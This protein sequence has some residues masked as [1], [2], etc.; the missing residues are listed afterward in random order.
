MTGSGG[1]PLEGIRVVELG[2]VIAGPAAAAVLGDWGASVVKIE[3]PEG[4]P[5]RGNR[6]TSYFQ[7]DNRGKRS[8]CLNLKTEAG[9]A[10]A[11]ALLGSADVFVT[12][13]RSAA[14]AR[15]GLDYQTLASRYPRLVYAAITGYGQ[16][17]PAAGKA[18]Y[19]IG[20]YWSRS[21]MALALAPEGAEPPV[22]RP[23]QGDHP[24][25]LA[26]AAGIAAALYSRERTGSGQL[27]STS[28]LRSGAY[29]IGSDLISAAHHQP[30]VPIA[31]RMMANPLLAVY[32][33]G[34]G[35]WFC[36]L[37]VQPLRHLPGV[38]RAVGR[39][40]L[41]DDPRF[42]DLR[43]LINH[44]H[45]L[46]GLLDEAFAEHPMDYWARRFAAEDVWWDPVQSAEQ[47]LA[48]P[49]VQA[50]GV[51]RDVED[52]ERKTI[53]T[54]VDFSAMA[55]SPARRAPEAGEHTEQILLENG[56][57]WETI[58]ELKTRGVIP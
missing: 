51:L 54:P 38:A 16:T 46:L 49:L 40:E 24:T 18:G 4:D 34:D 47:A 44:R 26:A 45:A 30:A 52:D 15:L 31:R 14:L 7:L 35:E 50:A 12:N 28:L 2:V 19:D 58:G 22:S 1:G 9:R 3:P 21:G 33:S 41:A 42:A 39:P 25:G 55:T 8:I 17:G 36:L 56:Y 5:Q 11:L 23:G 13:L 27:V 48:D 53:A 32:Q 6:N 10:I 29:A 37:G 57:D 20:A 43:S